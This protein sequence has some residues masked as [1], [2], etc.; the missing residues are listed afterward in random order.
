MRCSR[1]TGMGV[2][3]AAARSADWMRVILVLPASVASRPPPRSRSVRY[4]RP[5]P[6][7][8]P[9]PADHRRLRH[10][11]ATSRQHPTVDSAAVRPHPTTSAVQLLSL[12]SFL[13][14]SPVRQTTLT[15]MSCPTVPPLVAS[16][17][18]AY[19]SGMQ[20]SRFAFNPASHPFHDPENQRDLFT[21]QQNIGQSIDSLSIRAL[22]SDRS[23]AWLA[24]HCV[25]A[26][27]V[28][29]ASVA[30]VAREVLPSYRA[31]ASVAPPRY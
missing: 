7:H 14:P 22:A 13:A 28:V 21:N 20:L 11:R 12:G 25:E 18:S 29:S 27:T 31:A 3:E 15:R 6:S 5:P 8:T 2:R 17:P 26:T 16:H 19:L 30:S 9:A 4:R 23:A 10:T 24:T 1:V